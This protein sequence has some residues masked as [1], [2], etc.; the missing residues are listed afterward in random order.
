MYWLSTAQL[1][2][3]SFQKH[4][5]L[6]HEAVLWRFHVAS[7]SLVHHHQESS[8][9]SGWS[10]TI[11]Q[12]PSSQSHGHLLKFNKSPKCKKRKLGPTTTV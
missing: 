4:V 9:L 8:P 12:G 2:V 6:T 7:V 10:Q 5:S 3:T 1:P 11:N